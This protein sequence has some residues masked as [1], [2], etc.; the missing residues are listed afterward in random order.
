[1]KITTAPSTCDQ[2]PIYQVTSCNCPDGT[3]TRVHFHSYDRQKCVDFIAKLYPK[4]IIE[5]L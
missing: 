3:F 2:F 4:A 5:E 1:M